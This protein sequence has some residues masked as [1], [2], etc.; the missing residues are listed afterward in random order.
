M[1]CYASN[2]AT[3]GQFTSWTCFAKE[4]K[5]QIRDYS[6]GYRG[7]IH[8][9]TWDGAGSDH[10]MPRLTIT[11]IGKVVSR[12]KSNKLRSYYYKR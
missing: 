2:D 11:A 8:G 3:K 12:C 1:C 9:T 5:W 7:N 4:L 6:S 10:S